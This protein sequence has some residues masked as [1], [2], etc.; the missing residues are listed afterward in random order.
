VQEF[1][2]KLNAKTGKTYR[3]PTEAEW[4]YAA[5]GG[6]K[7]KGY[8]YSGSDKIED[9][10]WYAGNPGYKTHAVGTRKP[11]ELGIY[12]MCGNICEW[13]LDGYSSYTSEAQTNPLVPRVNNVVQR[14]MSSHAQWKEADHRVTFR[15]KK[16]PN[17]ARTRV[18]MRL[19]LH[20]TVQVVPEY[21]DLGLSVKWATF[22]VGAIAPE[23]Y[24][25]YF[26]WGEVEPKAEYSWENYKWGDGTA[27]NMTKYNE[28]D[29][30]TS[31]KL[32]D[33]AVHVNWGENW[34]M[35]T[36]EELDELKDKCQWEHN[37]N[38]EGIYGS[39]AIGPN[40]N[41]IFFPYAGNSHGGKEPG[42]DKIASIWSGDCGIYPYSHGYKDLDI[43]K[44]GEFQTDG[45]ENWVAQS[46]R[47]VCDYENQ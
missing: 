42:R 47:P 4:E 23:D 6:N 33:D 30:L 12:D 34:R 2:K 27:S 37:V 21:V 38:N 17:M 29:G 46:V 19:V 16:D 26:A 25:N 28:K 7:S 13:T 31:L 14:S 45:S 22:N 35:P 41:S 15:Y 1:I 8:K 24:G 20:D 10:A 36:M 11:N 9:V 32:E 18:G 5:R 43:F 40:G 39:I 44:D 3:L